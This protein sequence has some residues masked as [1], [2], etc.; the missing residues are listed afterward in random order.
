MQDNAKIHTCRVVYQFL[1]EKDDEVLVR[2]LNPIEKSWHILKQKTSKIFGTP[3]SKSELIDQTFQI[4][5][6]FYTEICRKL[7]NCLN[8]ILIIVLKIIGD[9]IDY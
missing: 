5:S 7:T 1:R 3:N 6:E 8:N 4:W 9:L 2:R